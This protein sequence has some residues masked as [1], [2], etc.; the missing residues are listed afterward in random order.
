MVLF[1][2]FC[3]LIRP[4]LRKLMLWGGWYYFLML[5]IVLVIIKI[6]NTFININTA[7]NP[8]YW[9]PKILF[10]LNIKT[11]GY[12]LEDGLFNFLVGGLATFGY[13]FCFRKKVKY[14]Y[15]HKHSVGAIVSSMLL[16][17]FFLFFISNPIYP[18]ILSAFLGAVIIWFQRKDLIEHSLLGGL[19]FLG[20]YFILFLALNYIFPNFVQNWNLQ[21]ISGILIIGVPLEEL[22]WALSLGLF[23]API[24]EY[25]H[26][27]KTA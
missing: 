24:Y 27:T 12:G 3:F 15:K 1:F 23:W 4:D 25:E 2:L 18:L 11:G 5:A 16:F 20:I 21:N 10:D 19:I 26:G 7:F 8:I 14:Q 13:E 9:H 6:L 17:V 22:L